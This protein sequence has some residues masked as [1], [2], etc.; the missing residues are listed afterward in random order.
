MDEQGTL[1]TLTVTASERTV[2][3][4]ALTLK[5]TVLDA[6]DDFVGAHDVL[7]LWE[8]VCPDWSDD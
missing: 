3:A 4:D 2:I 6:L 1:S 5:A 7:T 8:R